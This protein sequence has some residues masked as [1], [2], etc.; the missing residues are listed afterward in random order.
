MASFIKGW[1]GR[2]RRVGGLFG[3]PVGPIDLRSLGLVRNK[4]LSVDAS[5]QQFQ[6]AVVAGEPPWVAEL[7]SEP[8]I[9]MFAEF[10]LINT[11]QGVRAFLQI[12]NDFIYLQARELRLF[13]WHGRPAISEEIEPPKSPRRWN[14]QQQEFARALGELA[15]E[16]SQFDWRTCGAPG[17]PDELLAQRLAL[18]GGSGYA[19]LRR[20]LVRHLLASD[21]KS[22][23]KTAERLADAVGT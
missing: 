22:I 7:R 20:Q 17:L 3:A 12:A 21:S 5:W 2:G 4:P 10:S 15:S 16:L 8:E 18:R 9:A 11:D 13:S 14:P 1:D 19:E 23:R 6:E